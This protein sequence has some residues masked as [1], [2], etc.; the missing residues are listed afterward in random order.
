LLAYHLGRSGAKTYIEEKKWH[1]H[2]TKA[3]VDGR[4]HWYIYHFIAHKLAFQNTVGKE[5][6]PELRLYEC[7]DCQGK[8]LQELSQQFGVS[9]DM[10][11]YY[12]KWLKPLKVPEDVTCSMLIP[13]THQQYAKVGQ[14]SLH[15][16]RSK[17]HQIDY[18]AY[19]Q[20]ADKFPAISPSKDSATDN[21]LLI[22]GMPGVIAKPG[23]TVAALAQKGNISLQQFVKY[24]DINESHQVQPGQVY[25]WK[26][27]H[28]KAAVHY[29][30]VRP[31]E[32]WWSIAQKYGIKQAKL[33]SKNRLR[34][35]SPLKPG[36]VVWLRFIRP[37]NIP[38]AYLEEN[39][40]KDNTMIPSVVSIP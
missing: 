8:T 26:S 16:S 37:A 15:G 38:V 33:L 2:N 29:H 22:N 28:S 3:I 13:L 39:T 24:N 30:I 31:Q 1:I 17:K 9:L 18:H 19:W 14:L 5:L 35:I 7:R 4:A 40:S 36:Q 32:T 10:I 25:Y 34:Q 6:H 12:N 27:K 11:Q 21:I 23:D 20:Y